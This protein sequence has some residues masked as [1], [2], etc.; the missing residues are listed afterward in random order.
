MTSDPLESSWAPSKQ[1]AASRVGE[2]TVLLHLESGTYFGLDPVGTVIWQGLKA[3]KSPRDICQAI[4]ADYGQPLA[5]VEEDARAFFL[6]LVKHS[7][8][9]CR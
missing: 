5:K 1:A 6:E 8:I 9:E 7:L 4:S 2:E 3:G